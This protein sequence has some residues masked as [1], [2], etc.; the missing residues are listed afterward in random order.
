MTNITS[1]I[2]KDKDAQ[3]DKL[4]IRIKELEQENQELH[5]SFMNNIRVR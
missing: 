2:I 4:K 5:N 3:I 1:L